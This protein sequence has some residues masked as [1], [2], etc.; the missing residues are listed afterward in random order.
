MKKLIAPILVL[1]ALPAAAHADSTVTCSSGGPSP[2]A[3]TLFNV[4]T[5]A[6]EPATGYYV[7]PSGTPKG[8]VVLSH[9]FESSPLRYFNAMQDITS[10]TGAITMS[11]YY[12]GETI[13]TGTDETRGWQVREGARA[14]IAAAKLFDGTCP[15]LLAGRTFVDYGVSMGGNT[16]GLM[17]AAPAKRTGGAPLFDYWFDVEGVANVIE[18]YTEATAVAPSGN[19]TATDAT[20]AIEKE[21]GGKTLAE[22]PNAYVDLAVVSHAEEIKAAGIKGVV[23]VHGVGDGLV[24]YDQTREMEARLT[25]VG[26]STDLYSAATKKPGTPSGTTYDGYAPVPH[27]SPFAGH[28][29]EGDVTHTVTG[30]AITVLEETLNGQVAAPSCHREFLIDG[31]LGTIQPDPTSPSAA[32]PSLPH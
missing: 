1:L 13:I 11:M 6:G 27:D 19:T 32:C 16:S 18:T 5:S 7:V 2:S 20:T 17:A 4:T 21:N 8:L 23:M 26:V 30:T 31:T 29:G 14:G 28:G 24:P 10:K 15:S 22:A 9:G 3:A 12:P 25:Q